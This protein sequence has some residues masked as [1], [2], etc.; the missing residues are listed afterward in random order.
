LA[1]SI[2]FLGWVVVYIVISVYQMNSRLTKLTFS[3]FPEEVKGSGD[4]FA[5]YYDT[6]NGMNQTQRE[7]RLYGTGNGKSIHHFEIELP[8]RKPIRKLRFDPSQRGGRNSVMLCDLYV[9]RYTGYTLDLYMEAGIINNR[10]SISEISRDGPGCIRIDIDGDDP[11]LLLASDFTQYTKA[12]SSDVLASMRSVSISRFGVTSFIFF[13]IM[14]LPGMYRFKYSVMNCL[15]LVLFTGFLV[16]LAELFARFYYRDIHYTQAGKDFFYHRAEELFV[17][18]KHIGPLWSRGYPYST[19]KAPGTFR[20][21]ILGDSL[22]WGQSVYPHT[23]RFSEL[24]EKRIREMAGSGHA[25]IPDFEIVNL[26]IRG[27]DMQHHIRFV[28]YI[29]GLDPDFILY[30][31]FVNDMDA[32]TQ[33]SPNLKVAI[34]QDLFSGSSGHGFLKQYSV[35]YFLLDRAYKLHFPD[36]ETIT[37][38]NYMQTKYRDNRIWSSRIKRKTDVL[39]DRLVSSNI[40]FGIVLFPL[41]HGEFSRDNYPLQ[42]LH[43]I[44]LK[45]CLR[46]GITCLDLTGVFLQYENDTRQLWANEFDPHPGELA[47]AIAAKEIERVFVPLWFGAEE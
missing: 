41:W 17:T 36:S 22:S 18:E 10:N 46:R 3:V 9:H 44:V 13:G 23:R 24:L 27:R 8:A 45:R 21:V 15:Y 37:Y 42:F 28:S 47:H 6:G 4:F 40:P 2:L 33:R 11:Y 34:P 14:L 5:F 12:D 29:E 25:H 1:L 32:Y 43:Q 20:V 7:K 26:G 35:L 19:E 30:Q 16:V 31:W 38:T 39:L